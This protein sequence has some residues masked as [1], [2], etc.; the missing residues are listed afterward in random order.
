MNKRSPLKKSISLFSFALLVA[1]T[2]F[3]VYLKILAVRNDTSCVSNIPVQG[4][5]N[6]AF[7][8]QLQTVLDQYSQENGHVG[9]Q[10]TLILPNGNTWSGVSGYANDAR[11]CPM[12]LA[13]H[14]YIGSVTKTITAALVMQQ[15]EAGLIHLDDTIDRWFSYPEADRITIEMLLRHTSGIPSYT[16]DVSFLLAYLGRPQKYWTEDEL[17]KVVEDQPLKF[18]PGS[19]HEYSNTNFVIL[20]LILEKETG[21]TFGELLVNASAQ[22]GLQRMVYPGFEEDLILANGYDETI[23]HLGKRNLSSFRTS[24]VSGA[25]S[26]GG[27][28]ASSHETAAFFHTLFSGAWLSKDT[29]AQMVDVIEVIDDED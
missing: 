6:L 28:T 7:A 9:L 2:G 12:T 5:D 18:E 23:F 16:E 20:G 24:F 10:A 15:V 26:A 17:L 1:V 27:V 11:E 8:D 14:L 4:D 21:K 19:R 25:F 22:L 29:V 3:G 13:H